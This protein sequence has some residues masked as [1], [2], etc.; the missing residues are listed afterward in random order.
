MRAEVDC[1]QTG[2]KFVQVRCQVRLWRD[3][4][5]VVC[6]VD[7]TMTP[8]AHRRKARTCVLSS[9]VARAFLTD[10]RLCRERFPVC[11]P[12]RA[13]SRALASPGRAVVAAVGD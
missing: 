9:F 13:N 2:G 6:A 8:I 7:V 4:A 12:L 11:P 1:E 10:K 5:D 3:P